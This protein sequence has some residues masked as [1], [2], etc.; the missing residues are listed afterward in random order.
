MSLVVLQSR[1]FIPLK[2]QTNKQKNNGSKEKWWG[3]MVSLYWLQKHP[4]EL[5]CI[6][7]IKNLS[8]FQTQCSILFITKIIFLCSAKT[9]LNFLPKRLF[10]GEASMI[11]CY[12]MLDY[13]LLHLKEAFSSLYNY[14]ENGGF[15]VRP[16]LQLS[17]KV[18]HSFISTHPSA[19][20]D[21]TT[22]AFLLHIFIEGLRI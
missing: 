3:N 9:A 15:I 12:W 2:K 10:K 7:G 11:S 6:R 17:L 20:L 4:E 14:Y 22:I 18:H 5:Q 13:S 16:V 21:K 19:P 8:G 1:D